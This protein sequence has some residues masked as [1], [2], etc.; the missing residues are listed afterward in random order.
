MPVCDLSCSRNTSLRVVCGVCVCMGIYKCVCEQ[1]YGAWVKFQEKC[2]NESH[3][4]TFIVFGGCQCAD[5]YLV[6][7]LGQLLL[8][9]TLS[10]ILQVV[11]VCLP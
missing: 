3:K 9:L 8:F 10:Y 1:I 11:F 4:D 2:N 5:I 7:A 6:E